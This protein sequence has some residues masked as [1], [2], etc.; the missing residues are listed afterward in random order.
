MWCALMW[1]G[2]GFVTGWITFERPRWATRL[3]D[4]VRARMPWSKA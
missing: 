2:I 1:S 3:W 4:V